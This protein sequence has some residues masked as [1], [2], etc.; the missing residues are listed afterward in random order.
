MKTDYLYAAIDSRRA[1]RGR[2]LISLP[3]SNG[4]Y[5]W[6]EELEAP[7]LPGVE[8]DSRDQPPWLIANDPWNDHN[9]YPLTNRDLHREFAQIPAEHDK[10]IKFANRYGLLSHPI[11]LYD[12]RKKIRLRDPQL[13]GEAFR[14]WDAEIE[15]MKSLI[16]FWDLIC[17]EKGQVLKRG[18]KW[19]ITSTHWGFWWEGHQYRIHDDPDWRE[20]FAPEESQSPEINAI[21]RIR[22]YLL[23]EVNRQMAWH[24]APHL[25]RIEDSTYIYM[26][27]DCLLSAMYV[28][29]AQEIQGYDPVEGKVRGPFEECKGCGRPFEQTH[30]AKEYC[31]RSCYKKAYYRRQKEEQRGDE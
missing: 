13:E 5:R 6:E 16:G 25:M 30:G 29:F 4:G 15:R 31:T 1:G 21:E 3:V 10:I 20:E 28:L 22:Y 17:L 7:Q 8:P 12:T 2:F 14:V 27:P 19:D 24:V 26:V 23:S 9:S 18:V 11:R